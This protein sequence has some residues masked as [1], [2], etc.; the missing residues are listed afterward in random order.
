MRRRGLVSNLYRM[1]RL[2]VVGHERRGS[3]CEGLGLAGAG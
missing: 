2:D 1:A 3:R